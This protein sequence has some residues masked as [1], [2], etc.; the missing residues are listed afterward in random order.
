MFVDTQYKEFD[1]ECSEVETKKVIIEAPTRRN[2][3]PKDTRP[4]GE[5]VIESGLASGAR[6]QARPS[7][8]T[9]P[10]GAGG[11]R[12]PPSHTTAASYDGGGCWR[13]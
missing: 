4:V 13:R 8:H 7:P 2:G 1:S 6:A 10:V 3:T 9:C 5:R 12:Q 11:R